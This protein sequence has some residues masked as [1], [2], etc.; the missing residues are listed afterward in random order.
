MFLLHLKA[1]C[2]SVHKE[3]LLCGFPNYNFSNS[4]FQLCSQ[5]N[6]NYNILAKLMVSQLFTAPPFPL[7]PALTKGIF[8]ILKGNQS[9]EE[10]VQINN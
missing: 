1:Q 6:S 8:Y 5:F 3:I 4:V 9:F 7:K 2:N 10:L